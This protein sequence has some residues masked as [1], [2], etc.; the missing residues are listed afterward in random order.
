MKKSFFSESGL[1]VTGVNYWA[2][3]AATEMWSKWDESVVDKDLEI[4]SAHG[5][6]VI[7][8]F[9]LWPDFQ[10]LSR[11]YK[12]DG[13]PVE[14]RFGEDELPDTAAG[15]AGVSEVMMT[16]FERFADLA[17]KHNI[18]IIVALITGQMTNRLFMPP[19]LTGM[20]PVNNPEALIWEVRFVKYFVSR[21][22]NH[23]A[24][25]AWN[26]GNESNYFGKADSA[27]EA[28]TWMSLIA[29]AI[30]VSDSEH[31]LI[32]GMDGNSI[33]GEKWSVQSQAEHCDILTAHYY[34]MWKSAF[35]DPFNT[36]KSTM[37]PVGLNKIYADV[38]GLPCFMEEIGSWR[39]MMGNFET[40]V[41]YL[42]NVY[43]SLWANNGGGL[44]WWCGFDQDHLRIPP[45]DWDFPGLEHGMFGKDYAVR[46][47]GLEMRKFR[48]FLD[49][50]PFRQ[51]QPAAPDAVCILGDE[52]QRHLDV[53]VAAFILAKQA[54]FELEFQHARQ[55]LKKADLYLLP[56][57]CGKC[58]M[59][60]KNWEELRE[61]VKAGATLYLSMDEMYIDHFNEVFGAELQLRY[62]T[63]S[64]SKYIFE[65]DGETVQIELP[66]KAVH[67]MKSLG[68]ETLGRGNDGKAAFF[69]TTYG[70]GKVYLLN[71]P[72]EQ[73][74][75]DQPSA[76]LNPASSD[77]WKL[78]RNI[79]AA[80]LQ[81]KILRK[82]HPALSVTEHYQ[83]DTELIC[84]VVNN[85]PGTVAGKLAAAEN[86]QLSVQYGED[87]AA[88][89]QKNVIDL[90]IQGNSGTVLV[91]K[92]I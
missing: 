44:L 9:P 87:A 26:F 27:A 52:R 58:G 6:R 50:L 42:R 73:L 69:A 29:D 36:F 37:Y 16:R 63:A 85:S 8:V 43:W 41:A 15:R 10:P 79:A 67:E 22:K 64:G 47:T 65:L 20:N 61:R 68:A 31:P 34:V 59:S 54:G 78:Y 11:L 92:K 13:T 82:E 5:T 84:V 56:S 89:F 3:H 23:S 46:P 83:S 38:S 12:A 4:L 14:Y 72:L 48:D 76:F 7:R 19:G 45:Y 49:G 39:P 91:M 81:K 55:P 60:G 90:N 86:W 28:S 35:S 33:A 18:S 57:A 71:F 24:I 25:A 21:M 62:D 53:G 77:A 88:V 30:R 75:M 66:V 17:A 74:M 70:K 40:H 1:F 2:S 80:Q 51:L 32:S